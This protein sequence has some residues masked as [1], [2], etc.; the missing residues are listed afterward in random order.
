MKQ[1][2]QT[3]S[4]NARKCGQVKQNLDGKIEQGQTVLTFQGMAVW[5]WEVWGTLEDLSTPINLLAQVSNTR[6]IRLQLPRQVL[7]YKLCDLRQVAECLRVDKNI[8]LSLFF[9]V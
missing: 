8:S 3:Q 9:H 6:G 2:V 1:K 4:E 5:G 7:D